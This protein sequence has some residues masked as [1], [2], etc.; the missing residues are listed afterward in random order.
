[1]S[2]ILN[3]ARTSG[4]ALGSAPARI[5]GLASR[6][7]TKPRPRIFYAIVTVSVVLAIIVCQILLS[8]AVSSGAYEINELKVA[9]KDLSRT[10]TQVSQ[11]LAEVSSPQ[12]VAA[13]AEAL[14][15][16]TS[17]TTAYLRLSSSKV[18]GQAHAATRSGALLGGSNASLVQNILL[19]DIPAGAIPAAAAKAAVNIPTVGV[20]AGTGAASNVTL[21]GVSSQKIP[22]P[23]T[24]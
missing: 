23:Q 21:P 11:N 10:Y 24:R 14:G 18:L 13:S 7:V 22:T 4:R 1:M 5:L 16:V 9:H 17:N 20:A 6:R 3:S 2:A 8:V 15:M 19:T 12:H